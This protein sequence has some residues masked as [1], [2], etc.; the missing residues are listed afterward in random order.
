MTDV[1]DQIGTALL[2]IRALDALGIANTVGG[3]LAASFAGEPRS[4]IDVDVVAVAGPVPRRSARRGALG[5]V[6]PRRS[7]LR[8]AVRDRDQHQP[9]PR[10]PPAQSRPVRRRRHS[11]RA[12]QLARRHAVDAGDGRVFHVH[13]PEDILLQKLR[14]FAMGGDA[15]RIA[16]G[17]TFSG[18]VRVQGDR[19][20]RGYLRANAGVIDVADLLERALADN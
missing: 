9:H 10:Q 16:S 1:P 3:S 13:P 15:P 18:I 4:T 5:S 20:D 8:R 2:V 6:L 17:A 19:L 7:S 14:W 11:P 12:Q